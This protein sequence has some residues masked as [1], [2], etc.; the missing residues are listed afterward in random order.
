MENK[1]IRFIDSQYNELFR[2]KD[3]ESI[4]ITRSDGEELQKKCHFL[5]ECHTS[6]DGLTFHICEFAEIMGR[7]GSAYR[8]KDTPRYTLEKV[9]QEEFEFMFAP[10]DETQN[11]GC[12]CY[13]RGYFDNSINER[14]QSVA[15]IEDRDNYKKYKIPKFS[16]ECDNIINYFRFQSD[17]P[18]LKSRIEL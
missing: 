18:V 7:N 3:G 4:T 2:I 11:R 16:R 17:T 9:E 13:I 6:I 15:L 5:D 10:K 8:P 14:I 1:E 12:I